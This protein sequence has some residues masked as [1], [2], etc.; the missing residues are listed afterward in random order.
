M[1][2]SKKYINDYQNQLDAINYRLANLQESIEADFDIAFKTIELSYQ[3]ESLYLRANPTQKRNLLISLLSN[4]QLKNG[5]LYPTYNKPFDIFVEGVK[6][7]QWRRGW[8]SQQA[9]LAK[10]IKGNKFGVFYCC[11]LC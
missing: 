9:I 3:A 5:T 11:N 8:D 10:F 6:T 4:C 7:N 2:F 1:I